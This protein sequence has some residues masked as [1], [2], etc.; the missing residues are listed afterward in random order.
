MDRLRWWSAYRLAAGL[1]RIVKRKVAPLPPSEG[2]STPTFE[3]LLPDRTIPISQRFFAG[4]DTTVRG[5]ALDRLGVPGGLPGG[6]IN[7]EGFPQG[8]N[9]VII[10]NAELRVPVTRNLGGVGFIDAGNVYDL[11]SDVS[12]S[13]IRTG[14]GFG[15]RYRSPIGPIRIDLGFKLDRQEFGSGDTRK[16][17][18]LTAL[19]I[20][21]GQAF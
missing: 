18:R 20:S 19:H 4:G 8:G 1:V 6:T 10:L 9:A 21:I 16:K 3:V 15:V 13:Q 17:E 5:F 14:V 12:L 7:D 11:V 2:G